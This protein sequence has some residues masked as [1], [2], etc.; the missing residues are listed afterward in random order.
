MRTRAGNCLCTYTT[1]TSWLFEEP[2]KRRTGG[3]LL[4]SRTNTHARAIRKRRP[5]EHDPD[6]SFLLE[7]HP[8]IVAPDA[9]E[10]PNSCQ[11]LLVAKAK[12]VRTIQRLRKPYTTER[13]AP[14]DPDREQGHI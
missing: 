2:P 12:V 8:G 11:A 9:A 5:T 1:L 3:E 10:L 14:S 7:A 6:L 4:L 13:K